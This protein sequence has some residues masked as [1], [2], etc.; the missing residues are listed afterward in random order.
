MDFHTAPGPCT[1]WDIH[2]KRTLNKN[3]TKSRFPITYFPITNSFWDFAQ[4]TAVSLPCTVPNFKTMERIK[5]MLLSNQFSWDLSL[6]CIS[7]GY[8]IFHRGPVIYFRW[9][10]NILTWILTYKYM[11]YKRLLELTGL[12]TSFNFD[13]PCRHDKHVEIFI[14][15][16]FVQLL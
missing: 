14:A 3:L 15:V 5:Q 9:G 7:D 12:S 4:N 13:I 11:I 16:T 10:R 2:P 6:S 1:L 8:L